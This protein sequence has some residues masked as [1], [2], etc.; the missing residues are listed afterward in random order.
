MRGESRVAVDEALR[1]GKTIKF[2]TP[3]TGTTSATMPMVA[4][5]GTPL[6]GKNPPRY[7]DAEFNYLEVETADGEQVQVKNGA[8]IKADSI[9]LRANVG[10]IR[11]AMWL[12][13]NGD[14][15]G[16]VYLCADGPCTAKAALLA[17][18]EFLADGKTD[19]MTLSGRG[20]YTLRMNATDVSPFGEI[21]RIVLE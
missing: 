5:G 2:R 12:K 11:E 21:W 16:G 15:K 4:V 1:N 13:P 14:E 8:H 7:L 3:G 19:W 10:N 17:D 9:R 6:N 20:E 18:T